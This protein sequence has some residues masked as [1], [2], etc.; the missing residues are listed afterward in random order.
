MSQ[1]RQVIYDYADELNF[2]KHQGSTIQAMLDCDEAHYLN[3]LAE[4]DIVEFS[5]D[6][7]DEIRMHME[8]R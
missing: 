3:W 5:Q 1:Y 6:I 2:G 4:G 8:A 7:L